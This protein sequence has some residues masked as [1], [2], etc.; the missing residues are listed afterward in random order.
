MLM[1][2]N[3]KSTTNEV[4]YE[5]AR[6]RSG[7]LAKDCRALPLAPGHPPGEL[8]RAPRYA[9]SS[10]QSAPSAERFLRFLEDHAVDPVPLLEQLQPGQTKPRVLLYVPGKRQGGGGRRQRG[11]ALRS[12]G[13]AGAEADRWRTPRSRHG[14]LRALPYPAPELPDS[15]AR[16][17]DGSAIPQILRSP[18]ATALSS[19]CPS[20]DLARPAF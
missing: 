4:H 3:E 15:S 14:S 20:I 1:R 10:T 8:E 11:S 19:A 17:E 16:P 2:K 5:S 12:Q 18:L 6:G 13:G 9:A 7:W